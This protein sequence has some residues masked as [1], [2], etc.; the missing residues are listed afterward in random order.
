[1]W[2]CSGAAARRA[3]GVTPHTLGV[4]S[5]SRCSAVALVPPW[6]CVRWCCD[7]GGGERGGGEGVCVCMCA[8][9]PSEDALC[10][11]CGDI[12]QQLGLSPRIEQNGSHWRPVQFPPKKKLLV[13]NL[14]GG[15]W[16]RRGFSRLQPPTGSQFRALWGEAMVTNLSLGPPLAQK[17]GIV[18][19]AARASPQRAFEAG[20]SEHGDQKVS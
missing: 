1:M 2:P 20:S 6:W 14:Q 7:R 5:A 15:I 19:C 18:L 4:G 10:W 17:Q 11:C 13:R 16:G 8:W 9:S 12:L 3:R